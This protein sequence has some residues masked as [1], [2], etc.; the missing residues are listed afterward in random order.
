MGKSAAPRRTRK[1][2]AKRAHRA[3]PPLSPPQTP[4]AQLLAAIERIAQNRGVELYKLYGLAPSVEAELASGEKAT[5]LLEQLAGML[6][7]DSARNLTP[8]ADAAEVSL[9]LSALAA[10]TKM[11]NFSEPGEACAFLFGAALVLLL[12]DMHEAIETK[13][14]ELRVEN[15]R[16]EVAQ[17]HKWRSYLAS[18]NSRQS[19]R[20]K[21]DAVL[22]QFNEMNAAGMPPRRIEIRLA[23]EL[24]IEVSALKARLKRARRRAR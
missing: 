5:W 9:R 2:V 3:P 17:R 23:R 14:A 13:T 7:P 8:E 1:A 11:V 6:S 19:R 18:Y 4:Q 16:L 22:A 10:R 12:Y 24:G 15:E 20:E 21:S